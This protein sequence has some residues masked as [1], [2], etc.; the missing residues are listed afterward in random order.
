MFALES[1]SPEESESDIPGALLRM[2]RGLEQGVW[3]VMYCTIQ[4]D[5]YEYICQQTKG[6]QRPT[7]HN[8]A[9]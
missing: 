9:G 2:Y 6:S 5:A 3:S 1:T 8:L 4:Y 7:G